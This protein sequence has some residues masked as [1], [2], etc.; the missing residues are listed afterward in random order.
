[1]IAF[2]IHLIR[3]GQHHLPDGWIEPASFQQ[4]PCAPDVGLEG[5]DCIPVRHAHN[6]LRRQVEHRFDLVLA[7]RPPEQGEIMQ[8][9]PHHFHPL[10]QPGAHQLTLWHPIPHQTNHVC[11]GLEEALDQPA[12]DLARGAGHEDWTILPK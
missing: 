7:Q 2:P 1:M 8:L 11:P 12:A 4:T 9:P 5:A 6:A 3:R 10:K